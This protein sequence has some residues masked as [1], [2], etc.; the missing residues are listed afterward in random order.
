MSA[1]NDTP[2]TPG[3]FGGKI[4]RRDNPRTG[5]LAQKV[6]LVDVAP[7]NS[8][9]L[10][11]DLSENGLALQFAV[12]VPVV[13]NIEVTFPL[14]E[15]R[16]TSP[17]AL[18]WSSPTA[19]G[20]KFIDLPDEAKAKICKWLQHST[21]HVWPPAP[22]DT[23]PV[24]QDGLPEIAIASSSPQRAATADMGEI[25]RTANMPK[26][27]PDSGADAS[28][29]GDRGDGMSPRAA[30]EDWVARLTT[31]KKRVHE[32]RLPVRTQADE[33]ASKL[34][35][36]PPVPPA[37]SA[38][39]GEFENAIRE[40]RAATTSAPR[41]GTGEPLT[42][43]RGGPADRET[44]LR[45]LTLALSF[46]LGLV[47]IAFGAG[48]GFLYATRVSPPTPVPLP[49]AE[50]GFGGVRADE[51]FAVPAFTDSQPHTSREFLAQGDSYLEGKKGKYNCSTAVQCFREAAM[52]GNPGA[53]ERLAMLYSTGEC[54]SAN[55]VQAYR[56]FQQALASD[57]NP[58]VQWNLDALWERMTGAERT[59]V[60]P[61]QRR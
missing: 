33:E 5:V 57:P 15:D 56:A 34:L 38:D 12:A 28:P 61:P 20:L 16:I 6:I 37:Q 8:T 36:K 7:L 60:S 9:A 24:A 31:R 30:P 48:V 27:P 4:E 54:V 18:A 3:G 51:R 32:E 53:L 35:H 19:W 40:L 41:K 17:C 22:N 55:R 39:S 43:L 44:K 52:L 50:L 47:V 49:S 46:V 10:L 14:D 26:P 42:L 59:Q 2:E 13:P 23:V 25:A 58:W 29:G 1:R 45:G 11:V 21:P